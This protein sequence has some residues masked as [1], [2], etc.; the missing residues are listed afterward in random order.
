VWCPYKVENKCDSVLK[1]DW[2][3]GK[4][5]R[6][7]GRLVQWGVGLN[8]NRSETERVRMS[9]HSKRQRLAGV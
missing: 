7:V 1:L 8:E 9:W 5:D 6:V 3:E 2:R 4:R